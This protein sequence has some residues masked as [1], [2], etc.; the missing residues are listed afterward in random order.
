VADLLHR[1]RREGAR[2]RVSL[3]PRA[4]AAGS[5]RERNKQMHLEVAQFLVSK[6]QAGEEQSVVSPSVSVGPG[7]EH[8]R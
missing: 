7:Q 4:G 6:V 5:L 3:R 2:L 8:S 1:V